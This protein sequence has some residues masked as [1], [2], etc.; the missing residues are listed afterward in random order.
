M[1]T[2][3][4]TPPDQ[5]PVRLLKGIIGDL[6]D[7]LAQQI[8]VARAEIKADLHNMAEGAL[9]LLL[10]LG[11]GLVGGILWSFA[12]AHLLY[13]GFSTVPPEQA[14]TLPLWA[15]YAIVAVPTTIGG[16]ALIY[17]GHQ[18][19]TAV[20]ITQTAEAVKENVTWTTGNRL[21]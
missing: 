12:F 18:K 21:P 8:G 3:L 9:C 11:S 10:G 4:E 5:S 2:G 7:L 17:M 20:Q 15:C 1:A 13:W 19:L 6:Q 16:A 14:T